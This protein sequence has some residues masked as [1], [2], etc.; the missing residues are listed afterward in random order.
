MDQVLA[1]VFLPSLGSLRSRDE[2]D[3]GMD[4]TARRKPC[5]EEKSSEVGVPVAPPTLDLD[6]RDAVELVELGVGASEELVPENSVLDPKPRSRKEEVL[7]QD[8]GFW[9][10]R[11]KALR[12][13]ALPVGSTKNQLQVLL[14]DQVASGSEGAEGEG[15]EASYSGEV[16]R[17]RNQVA[18]PRLNPSPLPDRLLGREGDP[19]GK[20]AVEEEVDVESPLA[21]AGHHEARTEVERVENGEKTIQQLPGVPM[22]VVVVNVEDQVAGAESVADVAAALAPAA[23]LGSPEGIDPVNSFPGKVVANGLAHA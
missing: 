3:E 4:D 6:C 1:R 13:H 2:V 23:R 21:L 16:V 8:L 5:S 19:G 18:P 20:S 17:A 11:G 10:E 9:D 15:V 12:A 22:A 14:P 7:G